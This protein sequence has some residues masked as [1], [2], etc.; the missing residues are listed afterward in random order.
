[1]AAKSLK[2]SYKYFKA[3]NEV[4]REEDRKKRGIEQTQEEEDYI[5]TKKELNQLRSQMDKDFT[6]MKTERLDNENIV[7]FDVKKDN[8]KTAKE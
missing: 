7:P 8:I 5:P 4:R 2:S 3:K 1:M 6:K